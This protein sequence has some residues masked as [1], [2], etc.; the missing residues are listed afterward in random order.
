MIGQS[1]TMMSLLHHNYV[2]CSES[3][4]YSPP[5]GRYNLDEDTS[6]DCLDITIINDNILESTED[7]IGQLDGFIV[8]GLPVQSID[9][10]EINPAQTLVQIQDNDGMCRSH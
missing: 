9:G 5:V 10:V 2:S 7:L 1:T 4:D 6:M 3:S 8:D